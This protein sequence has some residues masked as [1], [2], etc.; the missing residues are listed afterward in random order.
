LAALHRSARD[1]VRLRTR[2]E[3]APV[4]ILDPPRKSTIHGA[5]PDIRWTGLPGVKVYRVQIESRVPDG[6][7][8][9]GQ[10]RT[11]LSFSV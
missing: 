2:A 4:E 10:P 1:G 6:L 7:Y 8:A 5:R 9:F 11:G 3:C